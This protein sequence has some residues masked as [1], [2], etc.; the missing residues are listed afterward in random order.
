MQNQSYIANAFFRA[1]MVEAWGRGKEKMQADCKSAGVSAPKLRCEKTGLWV[2]FTNRVY[3]KTRIKTRE[4]TRE[5]I[6]DLI[7][8]NPAIT[9]RQ[10]ADEIGISRKGIEWQIIKCGVPGIKI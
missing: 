5:K 2:E 8:K 6:L 9:M 10:M 4:I 1:G 3:G 7:R